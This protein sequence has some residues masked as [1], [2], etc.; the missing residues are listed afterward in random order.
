MYQNWLKN[1]VT[2]WCEPSAKKQI[3]NLKPDSEIK[4]KILTIYR[5]NFSHH[6]QVYFEV[7]TNKH[8]DELLG[9]N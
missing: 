8:I 2:I 6:R 7:T 4:T 3:E 1:A 9:I 5:V